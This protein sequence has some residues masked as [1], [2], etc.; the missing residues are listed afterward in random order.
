MANE[1]MEGL[2]N[3]EM[4]SD[5]N[6]GFGD[7]LDQEVA[8]G[9]KKTKEPEIDWSSLKRKIKVNGEEREITADEAIRDYQKYLAADEKF[10]SA[11]EMNKRAKSIMERYGGLEEAL[12]TG[13]Y[14][15]L[16]NRIPKEQLEDIAEQIVWEK[17]QYE[18]L[19]PEEKRIKE[20]EAR[21]EQKEAEEKR[22]KEQAEA[23]RKA[24]LNAKAVQDIDNQI[25]NT[26]KDLGVK[27]TPRLVARMAQHMLANLDTSGQILEGKDAYKRSMH[28]LR[29]DVPDYLTTLDTNELLSVL[30]KEV[31]N[32]I[33]KQSIDEVVSQAPPARQNK[34]D[35]FKTTKTR[36]KLK[37][38][39]DDFF[40][41]MDER[42]A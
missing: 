16:L 4:S 15:V 5:D 33:R 10:R 11:A 8:E 14:D 2:E 27:P 17:M 32:A 29:Q 26:F 36:S 13:K 28:D 37:M 24:E 19:S 35:D 34:K 40:K 30:P 25:A 6:Q 31:V 23:R 12:N 1:A 38:S 3:T 41:K 20:L 18:Q 39:T 22:A 42:F 7:D 21:V 9:E